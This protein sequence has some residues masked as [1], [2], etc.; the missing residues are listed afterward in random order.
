[1]GAIKDDF[2]LFPEIHRDPAANIRLHLPHTPIRL[3]R[4]AHQHA[5][6]QNRVQVAHACLLMI[7]RDDI[8]ALVGS[9]ICHDLISPLGAIGNGVELLAMSGIA[10]SPEMA[11]IAESVENANA[12]IR[13][14]R[15]AYGGATEEQ[16]ISRTEITST[17]SAAAR[18]GRLSYFWEAEGEQPRRDVRIAFLLLQCF[19]SAMPRGGD[20]TIRRVD[21]G[22]ELVAESGGLRIEQLLWDSLTNPRLRISVNPAQ[23]QFALLPEVLADAKRILAVKIGTDRITARF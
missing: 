14:F 9:R 23:V 5:G 20:I 15:V 17:L 4:V 3:V 19:E 2:S 13:F 16:T 8:T 11:L 7:R 10:Q 21:A 12:K 22:W 18:G 6:G 1:M